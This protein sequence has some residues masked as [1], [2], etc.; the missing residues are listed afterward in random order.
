MKSEFQIQD[1]YAYL[2]G[3]VL[4][5]EKGEFISDYFDFYTIFSITREHNFYFFVVKIF[6]N[7]TYKRTEKRINV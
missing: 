1:F 2:I 7:L 4:F 5:K 3:E 6:T